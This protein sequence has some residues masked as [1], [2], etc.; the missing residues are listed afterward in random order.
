MKNLIIL[1]I[2]ISFL[3]ATIINIPGDQN[4]IQA[5]IN[6][7]NDG[8]TVLVSEG[9]YVE[10]IN[11][12]GKKIVVGSLFIT[13]QDT[14]YILS[15]VIDGNNAGSVVTFDSE[16]DSTSILVGFTVQNGNGQ[17]VPSHENVWY[18]GVFGGG[19]Y[20]SSSSPI[21]KNLIIINNI[22]PYW[23]PNDGDR[24][25]GGGIYCENGNNLLIEE[26]KIFNNFAHW[27]GGGIY[28][29]N[30]NVKISQ[31]LIMGNNV[32]D[33]GG[34]IYCFRSKLTID[35]TLIND[36][37]TQGDGGGINVEGYI[38]IGAA[39][40]LILNNVT[41]ANNSASNGGGIFNQLHS[42]LFIENTLI[43]NNLANFGGGLCLGDY[44][45]ATLEKNT[46]FG[47]TALIYGGGM[48]ITSAISTDSIGV[49]NSIFWD[50]SSEAQSI[51]PFEIYNQYNIPLVL[52]NS[53]IRYGWEGEGNINTNPLFCQ[54]DINNFHLAENSPCVGTGQNGANIGAF[55]I[56]CGDVILSPVLEAIQNH[57]INEDG[58]LI[59]DVVA[60][61]EMDVFMTY[62]AESDTSSISTFMEYQALIITP[63]QNWSGTSTITVYVTD[64]NNL[65]DT[66]SFLFTVSPVNDPPLEFE[67]ISPTVLDTFQISTNT[68]E[69]IPFTWETSFDTDSDVTYKLTVTLDYLGTV[70]T[71]E[72]EYI[73]DTTTGISGYEYAVLMTNL[74]LLRWNMDYFIEASDEEFT[75]ISEEGKFVVENT[76]LSIE[77]DIIPE[78]FAL[79]QNYPNPFN[80]V[81][82][83]RYDLPEDELV[84]IT[85]YDMMG[86]VVK[87]LVNSSQTAGYKSIQWNATNDRNEPVS[88]GLY[89]YTIQSGE[90]RQTRK[91]VLLK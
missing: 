12:N 70:Y 15:T 67:L 53:N 81:T 13:T 45:N 2:C 82:S 66:T 87:M 42:T 31:S 26:V 4:T 23:G 43:Y 76:S 83:L 60:T 22:L 85:V 58:D 38:N 27:W 62:Y 78:V 80:P 50:N 47:N 88:A 24:Q 29:D 77:G 7:S 59:V 71:T 49:V 33:D 75:V 52:S 91:M 79:H 63:E 28:L 44:S 35:N 30:S 19:I 46:I 6:E 17:F 65:S 64:E 21:L 90:F 74:N 51:M 34:G 20:C 57:T 3:S 25:G 89:L 40:E 5:G 8:D 73:T 37:H 69:T 11:F 48:A 61:S 56:G 9:S 16:E 72:Y 32:D 41:I 55:G 14:T 18:D 10:N 39:A 86:R 84:N 68:D 1:S 54:P 36:N